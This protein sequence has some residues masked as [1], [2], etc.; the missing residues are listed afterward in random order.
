MVKIE[1]Q[2][3]KNDVG[4][5]QLWSIIVILEPVISRLVVL[6]PINSICRSNS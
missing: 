1:T 2:T 3:M 6:E 5:Y 4:K